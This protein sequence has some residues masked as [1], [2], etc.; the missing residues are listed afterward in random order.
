MRLKILLSILFFTIFIACSPELLKLASQYQNN[1]LSIDKLQKEFRKILSYCDYDNKCFEEDIKD[2]IENKVCIK[3]DFSVYGFVSI[4]EC[5]KACFV[6]ADQVKNFQNIG[7]VGGVSCKEELTKLYDLE[8]DLDDARD[9]L[10]DAE[11]EYNRVDDDDE[12]DAWDDLQDAQ[13]DYKDTRRDYD[14]AYREYKK[15]KAGIN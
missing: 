10:D 14:K 8:E 9:D 4:P 11:R 1:L 12:Q 2:Y 3:P 7:G 13:D 6:L 5:E 15:C